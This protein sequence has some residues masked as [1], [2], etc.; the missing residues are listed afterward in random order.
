[1]NKSLIV[2]NINIRFFAVKKESLGSLTNIVRYKNSDDLRSVVQNRMKTRSVMEFPGL[3]E[4]INNPDLN[5]VEF[6]AF[7][8]E[9]ESGA[10]VL[11]LQ[12]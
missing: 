6:D 11:T 7:E 3:R 10:F 9:S 12:N 5:R 8:N 4:I 1:M 2:K